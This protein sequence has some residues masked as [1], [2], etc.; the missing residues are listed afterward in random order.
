MGEA[1]VE[2]RR[3]PK[4]KVAGSNPASHAILCQGD[5][6]CWG[7]N[8]VEG[9]VDGCECRTLYE[10]LCQAGLADR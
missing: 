6:N 8:T 9:A 4:P 10:S 5:T 1:H 7:D 3:S 2:E